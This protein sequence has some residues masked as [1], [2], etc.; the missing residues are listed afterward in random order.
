MYA[1]ERQKKKYNSNCKANIFVFFLFK[2]DFPMNLFQARDCFSTSSL[3]IQIARTNVVVLHIHI[4]SC[5]RYR[6]NGI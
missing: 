6:A 4:F 2:D 3:Y 5:L 1:R